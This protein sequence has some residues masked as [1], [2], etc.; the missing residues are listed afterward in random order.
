MLPHFTEDFLIFY[1]SQD[2]VPDAVDCWFFVTS[3]MTS[4]AVDPS[5][6]NPL[7]ASSAVGQTLFQNKESNYQQ[8]YK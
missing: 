6:S 8:K 3:E 7:T 2:C 5:F 4:V 1:Q